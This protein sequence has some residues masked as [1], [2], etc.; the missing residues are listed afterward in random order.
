[1]NH[2]KTQELLKLKHFKIDILA[3]I[4]KLH[5]PRDCCQIACLCLQHLNDSATL[6]R[7]ALLLS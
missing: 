6:M 4:N 2:Q 3:A 5:F 7:R 1:M